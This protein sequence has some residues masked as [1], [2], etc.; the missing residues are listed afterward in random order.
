MQAGSSEPAFASG[1]RPRAPAVCGGAASSRTALANPAAREQVHGERSEPV[2]AG[3]VLAAHRGEAGAGVRAGGRLQNPRRG[4]ASSSAEATPSSIHARLRSSPSRWAKCPSLGSG[5]VTGVSQ[6]RASGRS[7]AG[8]KASSQ[9][10]NSPRFSTRRMRSASPSAGRGSRRPTARRRS[11]RRR[12][13]ANQSRARFRVSALTS[14][15]CATSAQSITR[16]RA[17]A[18]WAWTPVRTGHRSLGSQA[19]S[20]SRTSASS[21]PSAAR[22]RAASGSSHSR[23]SATSCSSHARP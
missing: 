2:S 9:R 23:S 15:S 3:V 13:A 17:K 20:R 16:P 19:A 6:R 1:A 14:R 22:H 11:A 8:R 4:S 18:V 5:L 10:A 12:S 21:A 7:S